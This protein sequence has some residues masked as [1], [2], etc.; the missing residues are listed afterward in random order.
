MCLEVDVKIVLYLLRYK[1]SKIHREEW[2]IGKFLA[3]IKG[4][5]FD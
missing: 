1:A 2:R 3:P 5:F 4:A